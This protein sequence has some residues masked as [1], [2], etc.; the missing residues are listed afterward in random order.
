MF[1][2]VNFDPDGYRDADS[3]GVLKSHRLSTEIMKTE[4]NNCLTKMSN[5]F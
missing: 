2:Q 5:P 1:E 3:N 4:P